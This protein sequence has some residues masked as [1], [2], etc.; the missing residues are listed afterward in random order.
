METVAP[1][2]WPPHKRDVYCYQIREEEPGKCKART[3]KV[4]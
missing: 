4:A 1:T 3:T 2:V